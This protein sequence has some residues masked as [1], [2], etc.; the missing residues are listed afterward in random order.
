MEQWFAEKE[1]PRRAAIR[2]IFGSREFWYG[3]VMRRGY[4]S[5]YPL[6]KSPLDIG[7]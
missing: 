4:P 6:R 2:L 3:H 7:L 1:V 5:L